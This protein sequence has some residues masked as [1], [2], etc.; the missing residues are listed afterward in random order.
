MPPFSSFPVLYALIALVHLHLHFRLWIRRDPDPF[1]KYSG[2]IL[3]A[4]TAAS[5]AY[6]AKAVWLVLLV[7]LQALGQ[8]F[9]RALAWSFLAYS[10]LLLGFFRFRPYV[11]LHLPLAV[12]CVAETVL[13]LPD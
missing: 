12:A 2:G 4:A 11:L 9:H 5:R 10:L 3:P 6:C 8:E 7:A 1:A 13:S